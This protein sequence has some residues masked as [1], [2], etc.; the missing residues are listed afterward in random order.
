MKTIKE[1]RERGQRTDS[2]LILDRSL[3]GLFPSESF[4]ASITETKQRQFYCD[5]KQ[6]ATACF[7]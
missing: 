5:I 3:T 6:E 7:Y 2:S 1:L 4:S